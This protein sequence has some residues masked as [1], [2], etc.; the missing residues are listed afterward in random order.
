MDSLVVGV[1]ELG[2][3]LEEVVLK[4]LLVARKFLPPRRSSSKTGS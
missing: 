2:V 3:G 1:E 4:E